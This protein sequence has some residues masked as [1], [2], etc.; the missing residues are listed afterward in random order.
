MPLKVIRLWDEQF[1]DSPDS[2]GVGKIEIGNH[3]LKGACGRE[4]LMWCAEE[5]EN[6][7]RIEDPLVLDFIVLHLATDESLR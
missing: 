2:L 5:D 1:H 4:A 3:L 7:D 6:F